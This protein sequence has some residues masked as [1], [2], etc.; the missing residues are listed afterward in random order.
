MAVLDP[1]R[2]TLTNWE[3]GNIVYLPAENHPAH[4]E[5]GNREVAFGKH[6][7][8]EREDFMEDAPKKFFRLAARP[9]GALEGCLYHP[10]R[11]GRKG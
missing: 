2:V 1:I 11:R 9:R 7:L 6:L 4:P 5:M 3:E 10:L 8:I